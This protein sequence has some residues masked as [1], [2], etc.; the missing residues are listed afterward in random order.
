MCRHRLPIGILIAA[1]LLAAPPLT[2]SRALAEPIAYPTF[3]DPAFQR[4]WERWDRP[5]FYGEV[6]RSYTWGGQ[7]SDAQQEP[8]R[9]G[10]GGRHLVQYFDKSRMEINHPD[11]DPSSPFYVTQGLLARDMIRGEFQEG[12]TTFRPAPQG[13]ARVPFGDLDDTLPTSP[14][15][16]SFGQVLGAAPTPAGQTIAAHLDRA[17]AVSD[18]PALAQYG[19]TSAGV[20]PGTPPNARGFN[21][22]AI[23]RPFLEYIQQ[24]GPVYEGG[25]DT[26]AALYAPIQ[27]VFG[28]PIT[29]A[30]WATVRAAGQPRTVLI[31]CFERRCLTYTPSNPGGFQVEMANT[32]LE[33]FT[34]RYRQGA[35]G[36]TGS[37]TPAA[38]PAL[39]L[40]TAL[41]PLPGGRLLLLGQG[42][43][44]AQPAQSQRYDPA[45]NTWAP[46]AP[47][48]LPGRFGYAVAPLA[49]GRVLAIGGVD[50][51]T[52]SPTNAVASVERYDPATNRWTSAA[53][54][55]APRSGATA[56][57]LADGR[58]LV[59]GGDP[60]SVFSGET[61]ATAEI[62]DPARDTWTATGGMALARLRH[63]ATRLADGRILVAGGLAGPP[64]DLVATAETEIYDPATGHWAAAAP[65]SVPRSLH[66]AAP[67][68]N[69]QMLVIG[70][71]GSLATMAERYD[72]AAN[73][74]LATAPV[75]API[76]DPASRSQYSITALS[77]GQALL[78]GGQ[79]LV[80]RTTDGRYPVPTPL[81]DTARYD[82]A[83]DRWITDAPL[84]TPRTLHQA[85]RLPDGRVLVVGPDRRTPDADSSE[86]YTPP[87]S[88]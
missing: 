10:P 43:G 28:F 21:Q 19:V 40:P 85:A 83:G 79:V 77:N 18:D 86:I 11:A 62:Y 68:A 78:A 71:G 57:V 31:Q 75:P 17:G 72:P 35:S 60:K 66:T 33:Y 67:L 9:E 65:M 82:P 24:V 69:G 70:G 56:T 58:V 64:T 26:T 37:W 87:A 22:H 6:S 51:N 32:G 36:P 14:T 13:P 39:V 1:L 15:Y 16:A 46:T 63:T 48:A 54:L 47:L 81:A 30:Y 44:G 59:A 38:A 2:A 50:L 74:W 55:L 61:L 76:G 34:W 29:E 27:Y 73:R 8:Y 25:R 80:P 5:V 3:A 4:V 20:I 49:D 12:D 42:R 88:P 7:V 52:H 53:P 41:V 84:S 45:T 23:A